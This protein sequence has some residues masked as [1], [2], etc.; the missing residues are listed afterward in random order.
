MA[1]QGLGERNLCLCN[2]CGKKGQVCHVCH[3]GISADGG[4]EAKIGNSLFWVLYGM[5]I[6]FW[7]RFDVSMTAFEIAI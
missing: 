4:S 6:T 3:A 1:E 2:L 5:G 7:L